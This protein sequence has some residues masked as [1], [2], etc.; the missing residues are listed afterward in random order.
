[1]T[2]WHGSGEVELL[3]NSADHKWL[4]T[5]RPNTI[6]RARIPLLGQRA[7]VGVGDQKVFEPP[8]VPRRRESAQSSLGLLK[9]LC[10]QACESLAIRR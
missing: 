5:Q 3:D 2:D 9:L 4:R 1:M 6:N 8:I 10:R 7:S